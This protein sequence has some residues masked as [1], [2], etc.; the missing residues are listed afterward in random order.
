MGM[1]VV[2][3]SR[4]SQTTVP[5]PVVFGIVTADGQMPFLDLTV[6]EPDF[7][8]H[9]DARSFKVALGS[10]LNWLRDSGCTAIILAMLILALNG[11]PSTDNFQAA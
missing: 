4:K 2:T 8:R 9:K 3:S 10:T 6:L 1:L 5:I 11:L 7:V